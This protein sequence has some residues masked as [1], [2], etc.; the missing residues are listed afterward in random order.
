MPRGVDF[1]L[2]CALCAGEAE[3]LAARGLRVL[4]EADAFVL[5]SKR[6]SG[7]IVHF[8]NAVGFL[9]LTYLL[10]FCLLIEKLMFLKLLLVVLYEVSFFANS[11]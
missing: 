8:G 3:V 4:F 2:A 7:L 9:S 11:C 1:F 6:L 10:P 5:E